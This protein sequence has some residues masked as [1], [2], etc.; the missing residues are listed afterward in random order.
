MFRGFESF[1]GLWHGGG[2]HVLHLAPADPHHITTS[3][4]FIDLYLEG[5]RALLVFGM[6]E[7]IMF[8]TWH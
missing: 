7:G 6:A 3:L 5:L 1:V 8:Y 2:D 4:C